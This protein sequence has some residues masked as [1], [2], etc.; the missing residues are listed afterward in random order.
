VNGIAEQKTNFTKLRIA[1]LENSVPGDKCVKYQ[2][3]FDKDMILLPPLHINLRLRESPVKV[4]NRRGR[5]FDYLNDN[6]PKLSDVKLK[7]GISN[8]PQIREIFSD[9]LPEHLLTETEKSAWLR[10][11]AV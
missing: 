10:L 8:E 4:T 1:P 7:E 3:L 6:F 2:P 5:G 11:K 9:D